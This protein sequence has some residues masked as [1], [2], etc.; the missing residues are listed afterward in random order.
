MITS[1]GG[2]PTMGFDEE[3]AELRAEAAERRS[4]AMRLNRLPE[5]GPGPSPGGTSKLVS[6]PSEKNAAAGTIQNELLT[7][8]R[9][10]GEHADEANGSAVRAFNG[11]VTATALKE[12]QST[13]DGQVKTLMGRL[14]KERDGLRDTVTTLA[15]VDVDRRDRINGIKTPSVFDGYK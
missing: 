7:S 9:N 6:T 12:V 11:W 2:W 13:W 15:G 5:D 10:A 1:I 4:T 3:W 8:T 14:R